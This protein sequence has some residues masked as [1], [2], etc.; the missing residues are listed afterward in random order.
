[1]SL[2]QTRRDA[3]ARVLC[4]R[5][6]DDR[7]SASDLVRV[8]S[9]LSEIE[10]VAEGDPLRAYVAG[11][12][13]EPELVR[14]EGVCSALA[15]YGVSI[16]STWPKVVRATPGGGNPADASRVERLGWVE[17]CL[18]EVAAADVV[19][20]LVPRT[21]TTR[22]AWYELGAAKTLGKHLVCAGPTK[23]SVFCATADEFA[24]DLDAIAHVV[25]MARR[26]A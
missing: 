25:A 19:L 17:Q 18:A 10:R 9:A 14:V 20:F 6:C 12:S 26:R 3:L 22:G 2:D 11:S 24:S 15:G 21:F 4:A 5:I 23:Q 13:A 16:V 8:D 7:R 1:M